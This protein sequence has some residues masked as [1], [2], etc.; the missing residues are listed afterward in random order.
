MID[1]RRSSC[2]QYSSTRLKEKLRQKHSDHAL[3]RLNYTTESAH[4]SPIRVQ[5]LVAWWRR[6]SF[7]AS[8]QLDDCD[9]QTASLD[10]SANGFE[11]QHPRV[12]HRAKP[13]SPANLD[14]QSEK[15]ASLVSIAFFEHKRFY[16][17]RRVL[18]LL[19]YT[20]MLPPTFH[21]SSGVRG[22]LRFWSWK[23]VSF[24]ANTANSRQKKLRRPQ[25]YFC[26]CVLT[27][28]VI[29]L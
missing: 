18:G 20:T 21:A 24:L 23:L 26:R 4:N 13:F 16:R 3:R 14:V 11:G 2:M 15:L 12:A 8:D 29:Y 17:K 10:N 5:K 25:I 9:Q 22:R 19:L 28:L 1:N 27:T 7:A 6:N